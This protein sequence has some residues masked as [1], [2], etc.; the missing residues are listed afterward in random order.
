MTEA[1]D[2]LAMLT[3]QEKAERIRLA[4][5]AVAPLVKMKCQIFMKASPKYCLN[6]DTGEVTI[7]DDGLTPALREVVE[8]IDKNIKATY[9]SILEEP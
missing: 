9:K 1:I 8:G 3:V 4:H 2:K 5:E 7:M 6:Q